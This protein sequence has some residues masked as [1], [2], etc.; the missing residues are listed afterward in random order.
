VAPEGRFTRPGGLT[1]AASTNR[2]EGG[3]RGE[4]WF[5]RERAGG[6]RSRVDC[7]A[8]R[9]IRTALVLAGAVA[10]VALLGIGQAGAASTQEVTI[11]S[12]DGTELAATF[13][14]PA[15]VQ[16]SGGWPAVILMHGLG[17][18]R[19]SMNTVAQTMRLGDRYA[20]LTY[21][22]RGHGASKGL[23]GIDGP[24]E[25]ADVKAVFAW[26]RDR[27][28]VADTRIGGFGIS[29]GG[30]AA[31][32]S[33]VA[34][35]PWAALEVA[36]TW[37]DLRSALAPQNLA[38]TGVVALFIS[39]LDPARVAPEVFAIRDAAFA[40][41]IGPIVPWAAQR[42][43]LSALKGV[44]TPVFLMQGRRDFAFGLEQARLAYA[45]L[46]GPKRFW[47]GLHGHAPSTFP[48]AD[49]GAMLA[50]G[51]G[52]FDR[53]L[54]GSA[55]NLD[56]SKP[57][58]VAPERWQGKPMRFAALPKTI[59][60]TVALPG[61]A[62]IPASGKVQRATIA[63]S[64][65]LEVFGAPVVKVTATATGGWTRLVAV[66]SARTPAGKE[67]VIAGGGVPTRPGAR[68]Y[69][70]SLSDQATFV[71][72]GSKLTVTLAS[73]SLAQN[74]GNLLY[75]DLPQPAG[76]RLAIGNATL[77]LPG[78]AAPVSR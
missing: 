30:G 9:P 26:L 1:T 15:G 49:S 69:S 28:D 24:S 72:K 14:L 70:I 17:G 63:L 38:K 54:R 29:Y 18:N 76:A 7:D 47:L 56:L 23:I 6:E 53:Y 45:A 74:A 35:V 65:P 60:S 61:K 67:I 73:S 37:T 41:R 48:A 39:S 58:A 11:V 66:L 68:T 13:S 22:A 42:S 40:G 55:G 62:S 50:E 64:R 36:E 21:D 34:G 77:R 16:P 52:W 78:L 43:S 57:V 31:L 8:V 75:L 51:A 25:V 3:L 33:L 12:A 44:K 27:P 20:V 10:G 71:P 2:E 19:S 32:N 5:P 4:T 59:V 46:A